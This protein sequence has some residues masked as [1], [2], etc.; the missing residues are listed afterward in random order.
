MDGMFGLPMTPNLPTDNPKSA[1]FWR[2]LAS[3]QM[4]YEMESR[5]MGLC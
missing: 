4:I 1:N 5:A 3:F 2:P